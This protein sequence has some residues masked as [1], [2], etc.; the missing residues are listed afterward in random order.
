MDHSMAMTA[1][2]TT[3]DTGIDPA[4]SSAVFDELMG[5][6][7]GRFARVE[8]RRR[9]RAFVLGLLAELPRKNCWTI[10][11]H[12]GQASPHGMQHLLARASWDAEGVR[13]EVRGFVVEH[14][15]AREAILVVDE[16]G[17]VKKGTA[18]VGVQRQ[19]TGAAGRV[20]NSQVAVFLGY[21]TTS[22]HALIDRELYLPA[23]WTEDPDRCAGAGVPPA[24]GFATKPQ[25]AARMINRALE[26]GVPARWVTGDEVYGAHP[27]LRTAIEHQGLGYV[28]AVARDHRIITGAGA[29]R[30]DELTAHLP[31]SVWQRLPAGAGAKGERLHDWAWVTID[32]DQPGSRWL[33]VR[34]HPHTGELAFYRCYAPHLV[35]LSSLVRVAGCRWTIEENFQASKGRLGLDQH[36]VR[37]WTS[38][39][40]WTTLAVL[41]HAYLAVLTATSRHDHRTPHD[42]ISL[43]L[44]EISHLLAKIVIQPNRHISNTWNWS[45]WRRRHQHRARKS[46]YHR[47]VET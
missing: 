5:R 42:L 9:V 2:A 11:E 18:S 26:A 45:D 17:D 46:H 36:Q 14:L 8:P 4:G 23:S 7:A 6:I 38:W 3:T 34:R 44:N 24:T 15:G 32:I 31:A 28:L 30:A 16:T 1:D 47:R 41:A 19:Y 21:A 37:R 39:Y 25:L 10:V 27:G 33:L 22:G 12:A 40:R 35:A 43:T 29:V 20:E 13:D